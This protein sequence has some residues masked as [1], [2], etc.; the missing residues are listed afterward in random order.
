MTLV[1]TII[2][3]PC[4]EPPFSGTDEVG[5][6]LGNPKVVDFGRLARILDAAD[7]NASTIVAEK[8]VPFDEVL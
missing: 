1:A 3:C 5:M 8:L 7:H 6:V 4:G 2:M